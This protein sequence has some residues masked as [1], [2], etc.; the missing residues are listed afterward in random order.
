M[1]RNFGVSKLAL[2]AVLGLLPAC[3]STAP[4][5]PPAPPPPP[6]KPVQRID[7]SPSTGAPAPDA[8][9][10]SDGQVQRDAK[11]KYVQTWNKLRYTYG[12]YFGS[13]VSA[14]VKQK[15]G[16]EYELDKCSTV[17]LVKSQQFKWTVQATYRRKANFWELIGTSISEP[18]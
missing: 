10:P 2:V 14:A 12:D 4:R 1:L 9:C 6:P 13:F 15:K 18:F 8:R 7:A 3:K 17:A 11:A 16:D 5:E